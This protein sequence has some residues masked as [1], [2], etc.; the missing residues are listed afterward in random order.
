M[1]CYMRIRKASAGQ[2]GNLE[3]A[4]HGFMLGRCNAR[5]LLGNSD[6]TFSAF[7][8]LG[9]LP[10]RHPLP[11][12]SHDVELPGHPLGSRHEMPPAVRYE[13]ATQP[14]PTAPC[15]QLYVIRSAS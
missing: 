11:G 2:F 12:K 6:I 5:P 4:C 15:L 8:A 10:V 3:L 13:R 14:V 7:D 1:L 9:D